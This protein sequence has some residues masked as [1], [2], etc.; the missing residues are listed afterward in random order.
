MVNVSS[1]SACD[2]AGGENP[3]RCAH[4]EHA[5]TACGRP[6]VAENDM[7]SCMGGVYRRL[8]RDV[9]YGILMIISAVP[10]AGMCYISP[11]ECYE[12]LG[13]K[14]GIRLKT[15]KGEPRKPAQPLTIL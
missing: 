3:K 9:Q 4:G 7:L 14:N 5:H 6:N 12:A 10:A 15:K 11:P 13:A 8:P 1:V 2:A